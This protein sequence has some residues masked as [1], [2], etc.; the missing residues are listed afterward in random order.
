MVNMSDIEILA[1]VYSER[2]FLNKGLLHSLNIDSTHSTNIPARRF[3]FV[4]M[5]PF[6]QLH[7]KRLDTA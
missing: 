6:I 4:R 7:S 5:M 2:F 1:K 3:T